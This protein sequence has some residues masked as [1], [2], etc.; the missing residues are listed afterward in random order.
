MQA[1]KAEYILDNVDFKDNYGSGIR[2]Y[3][4]NQSNRTGSYRTIT[5][6]ECTFTGNGKNSDS[7]VYAFESI[8]YETTLTNCHFD[9]NARGVRLCETVTDANLEALKADVLEVVAVFDDKNVNTAK[10]ENPAVR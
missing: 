5:L 4:F 9:D 6:D 1:L 7:N 2:A 3:V 8:G 10:D